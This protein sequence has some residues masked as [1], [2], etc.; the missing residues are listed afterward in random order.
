MVTQFGMSAVLGPVSLSRLDGAV[1]ARFLPGLT[2]GER[3]FSERTQQ[4]VDSEVGDLLSHSFD[5]ALALL[6][7]NRK[8]L[9]DLA[10]RLR[11][12]EVLEGPELREV[13]AGAELPR[14][15]Q[16]EGAPLSAHH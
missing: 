1:E 6:E 11:D 4:V 2:L 16:P 10:A 15:Q 9:L 14:D 13:L 5:R 8:Q 3:G 7:H 12:K